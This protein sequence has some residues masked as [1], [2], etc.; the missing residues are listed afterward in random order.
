[1]SQY[2]FAFQNGALV[3]QKR[4][5]ALFWRWPFNRSEEDD[6]NKVK[7]QIVTLNDQLQ[8]ARRLLPK[9]EADMKARRD[10]LTAYLQQSSAKA[11]PMWRDRWTP[12]RRPI[13]LIEGMKAKK[14]V[15]PQPRP[16]PATE[17]ARLV[18]DPT[19]NAQ[20]RNRPR[21]RRS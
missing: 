11:G 20:Q 4:S 6:L 12:R 2:R 9:K 21:K 8:R 17:I 10:A 13:V 16:I 7:N 1:M 18:V 3:R 5:F 15:D 14:K 19:A